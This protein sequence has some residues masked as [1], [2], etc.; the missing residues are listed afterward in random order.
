MLF[1]CNILGRLIYNLYSKNKEDSIKLSADYDV[2][3]NRYKEE[4]LLTYNNKSVKFS[5]VVL[6]ARKHGEQVYQPN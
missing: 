2:I 5:I 4:P 6:D 1:V 3:C